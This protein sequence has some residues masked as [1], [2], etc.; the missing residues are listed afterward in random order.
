MVIYIKRVLMLGIMFVSMFASICAFEVRVPHVVAAAGGVSAVGLFVYRARLQKKIAAARQ[1]MDISAMVKLRDRL[2]QVDKLIIASGLVAG[3]GV[4]ASLWNG[5]N[6][7][8]ID[9]SRGG[10]KDP[11]HPVADY[12]RDKVN[13]DKGLPTDPSG[14][15]DHERLR[16]TGHSDFVRIGL[17]PD[18]LA[19]QD[20]QRLRQAKE[21][22]RV[23]QEKEQRHRGAEEARIRSHSALFFTQRELADF[24]K[25]GASCRIKD[26]SSIITCVKTK[27]GGL[28][29]V[30]SHAVLPARIEKSAC[31][32]SSAPSVEWYLHDAA[33]QATGV[34]YALLRYLPTAEPRFDVDQYL[35]MIRRLAS[36]IKQREAF[37]YL[38]DQQQKYIRELEDANRD[39]RATAARGVAREGRRFETELGGLYLRAINNSGDLACVGHALMMSLSGEEYAGAN[40]V[41]L[42][43]AYSILGSVIDK[44][45]EI[46]AVH[47]RT[48]T[49]PI[50]PIAQAV[51]DF[52]GRPVV[53]WRPCVNR[54][55]QSFAGISFG[56]C[57]LEPFNNSSKYATRMN[58]IDKENLFIPQ[59]GIQFP[60]TD[61]VHMVLMVFEHGGGHAEA[62]YSEIRIQ[63]PQ[64]LCTRNYMSAA[65]VAKNFNTI[66]RE[67]ARDKDRL[68]TFTAFSG[69]MY[70]RIELYVESLI[71]AYGLP[72][73]NREFLDQLKD[74]SVADFDRLQ[75]LVASTVE[76][77]Y[78]FLED[79]PEVS[80]S[81]IRRLLL[82]EVHSYYYKWFSLI[83]SQE[84]LDNWGVRLW[85][86]IMRKRCGKDVLPAQYPGCRVIFNDVGVPLLVPS[87]PVATD[88]TSG[89]A[90][91]DNIGQ[92]YL[93]LTLRM[94]QH[95]LLADMPAI[96]SVS[97]SVLD[98]LQA[99]CNTHKVPLHIWHQ[100]SNGVLHKKKLIPTSSGGA[101]FSYDVLLTG[102]GWQRIYSATRSKE[103]PFLT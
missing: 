34:V 33:A 6:K 24:M 99:V 53:V 69:D 2:Q 95:V 89:K 85:C 38:I 100:Q 47:V 26:G 56:E 59:G 50:C 36:G 83:H 44:Y 88:D 86:L 92:S 18:A 75:E 51:A 41:R 13:D 11:V 93:N 64:W 16:T 72:K 97:P 21:L 57:V 7:N 77:I 17:L 65:L 84:A 62:L 30:P 76:K 81:S 39:A 58:K 55:S 87:G 37:V 96:V 22:L 3:G 80:F 31:D 98:S 5:Q 23:S 94:P 25:E 78:C 73:N 90:V 102:D 49:Y 29:V 74:Q 10:T 82:W 8:A 40:A 68:Q 67:L 61:A 52:S 12:R 48:S 43:G 60:A 46:E 91:N 1:Q 70:S 35:A 15:G 71:A 19:A 63:D 14:T 27:A 32:F 28:L 66:I 9:M 79:T 54:V 42:L 20:D 4:L 101:D 103:M 45:R